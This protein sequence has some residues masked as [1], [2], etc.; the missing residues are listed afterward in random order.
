MSSFLG[1]CERAVRAS[2]ALL[3]ERFGRV[4][5]REKGRSDLVTEADYASQDLVRHILHE[6]FPDHRL[7]G[8]E[9]SPVLPPATAAVDSE[10][11]WILDP[12][13]GTT[14]YVHK[15]PHFAVSLALE[16]RGELL[17]GAVFDPAAN[18]CFTAA[19][20]EGAF[21]NGTRLQTS[22]ITRLDQA[23]CALGFP[24]VVTPDSPD[25]RLFLAA[26][27]H[28][29]SFR[30]MGSASLNL[31]YIAAGR[32]DA[33]WSYSTKAWDVAA[34]ALLV[35]EAGGSVTSPYGGDFVL[36]QGHILAAANPQILEQILAL[37][38]QTIP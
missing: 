5:Y 29:Q 28:C 19:A 30:R 1:I 10:Y 11:R 16:R 25:L 7:V 26:L 13:D 12:L 32:F 24:A 20:G 31:C 2:G 34:G 27:N 36:D 22:S 15:M 6:A 18:E 35:R 14:N 3:M 4:S 17:V 38:R 37:V 21:L 9:D 23:M 8:E 33:A